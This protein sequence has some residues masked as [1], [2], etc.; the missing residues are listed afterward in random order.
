MDEQPSEYLKLLQ[1][2]ASDLVM[3]TKSAT[4]VCYINENL[5][6]FEKLVELE[7]KRNG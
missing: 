7:R 3:H 1:S 5:K 4:I 6:L 2:I